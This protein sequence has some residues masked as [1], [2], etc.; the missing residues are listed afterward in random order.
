MVTDNDMIVRNLRSSNSRVFIWAGV[1]LIFLGAFVCIEAG[2]SIREYRLKAGFL[3]RFL[4]FAEW[5]EKITGG[6]EFTLIIG[7]MGEDSFG[8]VFDRIVGESVSGKRLLVRRYNKDTPAEEL[9]RCRVLYISPNLKEYFSDILA[10]VEGFPVLTV[11][12]MN[13]FAQQGGMIN[14]IMIEN[15]VAFEINK[16]AAER[17]GIILS[18]KLLRVAVRIIKDKWNGSKQKK[19]NSNIK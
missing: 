10:Q 18:S 12:E 2:N 14:F 3:Y 4:D 13:G 6:T 19:R 11:S 7:I 17:V 8:D 16:K 1:I 9:R 5:P 15:K